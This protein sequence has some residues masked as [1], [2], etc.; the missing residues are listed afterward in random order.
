MRKHERRAGSA[1]EDLA[2]R[3]PEAPEGAGRRGGGGHQ[4]GGQSEGAAESPVIWSWQARG[5]E[6]KRCQPSADA[7]CSLQDM[8]ELTE[9]LERTRREHGGTLIKLEEERKLK[10]DHLRAAQVRQAKLRPLPP[11]SRNSC[12]VRFSLQSP[13]SREPLA[14]IHLVTPSSNEITPP[15]PHVKR[16]AATMTSFCIGVFFFVFF[17]FGT[18][19]LARRCRPEAGGPVERHQ[20][21]Q[22]EERGARGGLGRAGAESGAPAGEG[23]RAAVSPHHGGWVSLPSTSTLAASSY[24]CQL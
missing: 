6:V 24:V 10:G 17:Y 13:L 8:R 21:P 11:E 19:G 12:Q 5:Q 14:A 7:V 22:Q 15:P 23:G 16:I 4:L 1:S 2:G 18:A 20:R 3:Q 9:K